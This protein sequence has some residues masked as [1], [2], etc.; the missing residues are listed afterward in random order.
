MSW[1]QVAVTCNIG[2]GWGGKRKI[3]SLW[4]EKKGFYYLGGSDL[5]IAREKSLSSQHIR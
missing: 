4:G 3:K 1:C 5:R 2:S